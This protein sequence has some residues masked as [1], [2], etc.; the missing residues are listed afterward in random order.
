VCRPL[1]ILFIL[2]SLSS[3][4]LAQQ[5]SL[6]FTKSI[7][8]QLAKV[9][10][11]KLPTLQNKKID[12]LKVKYSKRKEAL[13]KKQ[14]KAKAKLDKF[15]PNN[16]INKVN[17]KLDS[18]NPSNRVATK[19][20]QK[21]DSLGESKSISKVSNQLDS[22]THNK[23]LTSIKAKWDSTQTSFANKVDSLTR[24]R[25]LDS[26][27]TKKM[28]AL[29]SGLDSMKNLGPVKEIAKAQEKLNKAQKHA[30]DNV[31]NLE[32]K[33]DKKFSGFNENGG[34]VGKL[35]ISGMAGNVGLDKPVTSL[36]DKLPSSVGNLQIKQLKVPPLG[37]TK[38]T[39]PQA[40][41]KISVGSLKT[42]LPSIK[43]PTIGNLKLDKN[44]PGAENLSKASGELNKVSG[45][46]KQVD[47]YQKDI[48]QV[49]TGDLA[50][51]E[52]LP[53]A[54]E[55]K[56]EG[57]KEVKGVTGEAGEYT[58]MIKKWESDPEVMKEMALNKAKEQAVN[59]FAGHEKELLAAVNQ[60]SNMKSKYKD[61]ETVIDL[62]KK[63]A[64]PLKKK[65]FVERLIL[66]MGLQMQVSNRN[67]WFDFNPYV[68]YRFAR[69]FSVGLGWLER[70]SEDFNSWKFVAREHAYGPRMFTE[71]KLKE[72]FHVR[73]EAEYINALVTSPY[74]TVTSADGRASV[75]NYF[76][77][78]K[79]SFRFSRQIDGNVQLMYNLYNPL[80][81]SPYVS[82][83]IVRM[84]FEFPRMKKRGNGLVK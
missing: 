40:N 76:L 10:S 63:P 50:N 66:G 47:V 52:Q 11:L 31:K 1:Y 17:H 24:I 81:R 83:L 12:T 44:I 68:G 61:A 15:N 36:T 78:I 5:D 70:L 74:V 14:A 82:D 46:T 35:N 16:G 72:N 33:F 2:A 58:D 6:S 19:V 30:T 80:K 64:N 59:H 43:S 13:Q 73:A 27:V 25:K 54:L 55:T 18:L 84:G 75:F 7:S 29:Q 9:D 77:G 22:L 51:A 38:L 56:L 26:L 4:A 37:A 3:R 53:K 32:T 42:G 8:S 62:L 39:L 20:K 67:H 48:K 60:L 34:N 57:M 41:T 21:L 65:P 23:R 71:F 45:L 49:A 79:K 28:V 69:R